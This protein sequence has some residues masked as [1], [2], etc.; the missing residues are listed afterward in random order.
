MAHILR[1]FLAV[2]L[3]FVAGSVVNMTLISVGGTVVPPPEGANV[4]TME[5]LRAAMH[6]YEPKH[7]L[8]P[9]LAHAFGT[10]VGAAVAGLL[11]PARSALPSLVV[12]GLF[13]LGG[14]ANVF[15]LPSPLWFTALDLA[16]A[17]LP[18]AWLGLAT[19]KRLQGL[20]R[21]GA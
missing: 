10:L 2:I 21:D 12:G 3:G 4:A 14:I 15:M 9:F 16:L 7:F 18:F 17:Y 11:A 13:L 19:S 20:G 6:L 5:G 1:I 8:F